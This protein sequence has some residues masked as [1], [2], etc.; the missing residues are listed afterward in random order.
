VLRP[1]AELEDP[2]SLYI[3]GLAVHSEFRRQGFARQL[4]AVATNRAVTCGLPRLSLICFEENA[5]ALALYASLG[6][7][8]IDRRAVMSHPCLHYADGDAL[9]MKRRLS[10]EETEP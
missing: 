4:M 6:F 10:A 9:L 1:Y 7:R 2:G 8:E 5:S 3:S